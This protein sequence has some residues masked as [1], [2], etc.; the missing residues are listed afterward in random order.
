MNLNRI[1]SEINRQERNKLNE[2]WQLIE[3]GIDEAKEVANALLDAEIDTAALQTD[4]RNKLNQLEQNY[5]PEL[6][7]LSSQLADIQNETSFADKM[8][9]MK[10]DGLGFYSI[11]ILGDSISH[12]ANA[13]K[14]YDDAWTAILRKALQIELNTK[15]HGFVNLMS[16]IMNS[17]GSYSDLLY[18]SNPVSGWVRTE[19]SDY[20]GFCKITSS[21]P[22]A[23]Y[24]GTF[25]KYFK[26]N[27]IG[28]SVIK[29]S[30]SG[31]VNFVVKK[32]GEPTESTFSILNLNNATEAKE[33]IWLDT[34]NLSADIDY[35]KLVNVNGTNTIT[36]IYVIDDIDKPVVN[37]YARSGARISDLS[38]YVINTAFNTNVLFFCLGFNRATDMDTYL[39]KCK[40]AYDTFKPIVYVLDFCW[41]DGRADISAKLNEFAAYCNAKFI[42]TIPRVTDAQSLVDSGFLSDTSHPSVTGHKVIAE[43]VLYVIGTT[44]LSK[45][46]ITKYLST[47]IELAGVTDLINN[48]VL[49]YKGYIDTAHANYAYFKDLK[50]RLEVKPTGNFTPT[51]LWLG[52]TNGTN[53]FL[54]T[55]STTTNSWS[56][57]LVNAAK[58]VSTFA[59]ASWSTEGSF[60]GVLDLGITNSEL[61]AIVA[62]IPSGTKIPI[63]NGVVTSFT[64][65]KTNL[66]DLMKYN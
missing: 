61:K 37:N 56:A 4:I 28:I 62:R 14:I 50:I 60:E 48:G 38:D 33:I 36:G 45:E 40:A 11:N 24:M 39:N 15:N 8:R 58:G 46:S 9:T 31:T 27:K 6:S 12:G 1:N 5:A 26:I 52:S 30:S 29:N 16:P 25:Q 65:N 66:Y 22:N 19:V 57:Q 43:K 35:I 7:S 63:I 2:N 10:R 51:E 3:Q 49:R 32:L 44:F 13:P 64:T 17:K 54:Y 23:T 55:S 42:Q 53:L 41:D 34:S 18:F 47:E 20:L 59:Q 21:T